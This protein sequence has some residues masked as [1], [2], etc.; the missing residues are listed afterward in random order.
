LLNW[1]NQPISSHP[2]FSWI[3]KGCPHFLLSRDV[4]SQVILFT[5]LDRPIQ[6]LRWRYNF[7]RKEPRSRFRDM[8]SGC[9]KEPLPLYR[10]C[11]YAKKAADD[12][13]RRQIHWFVVVPSSQYID[14]LIAKLLSMGANRYLSKSFHSMAAA[15]WLQEVQG[16]S[17]T[18]YKH[19]WT[20]RIPPLICTENESYPSSGWGGDGGRGR[21]NKHVQA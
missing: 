16:S 9:W 13:S 2:M 15:P 11:R 3:R 20:F 14:S 5:S 21:C 4:T 7:D 12:S 8:T 17:H 18:S 1:F 6:R 10:S 19:V